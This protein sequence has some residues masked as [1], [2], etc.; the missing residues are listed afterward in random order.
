MGVQPTERVADLRFTHL[1]MRCRMPDQNGR[2]RAARLDTELLAY[3]IKR[4]PEVQ[5]AR[6][7]VLRNAAE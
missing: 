7:R 1:G 2:T 3:R 4:S 6:G 5:L